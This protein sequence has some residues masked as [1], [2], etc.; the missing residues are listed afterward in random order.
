MSEWATFWTAIAA[1][2]AGVSALLSAIYTRL[3]YRMV[4]VQS[5]PH[6]V[7]YSH[8]D[9]SRPTILEIVIENIGNGVATDAVFVTSRPV[10]GHAFGVSKDTAKPHE[11]MATGPLIT[12]IPLL[13]PKE[14][15]VIVWGQFG[16]LSKALGDGYITVTCNYSHGSRPMQSV[17][18]L[19]ISSFEGTSASETEAA[20]AVKELKRIGDSS[21]RLT[22]AVQSLAASLERRHN[23]D[24]D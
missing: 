24:D 13:A 12:G 21:D 1:V 7:V 6:I 8:H 3:S 11:L 10:P 2:A 23:G 19:E 17:S 9:E 20:R 18:R 15:R 5:E 4:Q 22:R 16:G 14:K